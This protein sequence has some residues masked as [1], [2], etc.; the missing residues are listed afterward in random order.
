MATSLATE[1]PLAE[2]AYKSLRQGIVRCEFLPG[3]RLAVEA[4]S[5]HFGISSSPLR[6]ALSRLAEQG[7]VMALENRGFRVAPLT[8][9]GVRDLTRMRLLL[10]LEALRDAMTHGDDD[11]EAAIVAAAH[12]LARRERD[13]ADAS[14]ALDEDWSERHRRFHMA[15]IAACRSPL[16]LGLV[17]ELSDS[18][19]RYRRFSA[20]HRTMPRRKHDEHRRIMSA[21]LARKTD[22]AVE[23][24]REHISRTERN[25]TEALRTA[26][27]RIAAHR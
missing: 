6:E 12:A 25:V 19:E 5:R 27:V 18:A 8:V 22:V 13:L 24:L 7:L 26:Q 9:E 17:A 4:L 16:M 21:V 23:L 20:S 10:E 3:E 15:L 2:R 11:W 1:Q 14:P